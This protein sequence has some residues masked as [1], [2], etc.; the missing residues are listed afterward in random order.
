MQLLILTC[1]AELCGEG[2]GGHMSDDAVIFPIVHVT[3]AIVIIAV[4]TVCSVE[5]AVVESISKHF[6]S[7]CFEAFR[8]L[9]HGTHVL[10]RS[11]GYR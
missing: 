10:Y 6:C 2:A 4:I 11:I 7:D 1:P 3:H 9:Q 5:V 8:R